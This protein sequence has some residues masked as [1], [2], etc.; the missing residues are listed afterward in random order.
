[1]TQ[2]DLNQLLEHAAGAGNAAPTGVALP[3]WMPPAAVLVAAGA[4][5]VGIIVWLFGGKLIKPGFVLIGGVLGSAIGAVYVPMV[6]PTM[7]GIP[8]AY[9]G[10]L[11]GL[12]FGMIIALLVYRFAMACLTAGV[13]GAAAVLAGVISLSYFP[14]AIPPQDA[15]TSTEGKTV[16]NAG[17]TATD[18]RQQVEDQVRDWSGRLR[19]A[20]QKYKDAQL[21]AGAAGTKG[22]P[23]EGQGNAGFVRTPEEEAADAERLDAAKRTAQAISDHLAERWQSLPERSR[24]VIAGAWMAGAMA[25]FL[26]GLIV[27]NKGAA[28][29]SALTGAAMMLAGG[30]SALDHYAALGPFASQIGPMGWLGAWLAISAVGLYYQSRKKKKATLASELPKPA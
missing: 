30:I 25:G 22:T 13:V 14:G 28:A 20:A 26:L 23:A 2:Q 17:G 19:D 29:V 1:M 5:V 11:C 24:L 4:L 7:A 10:M 3:P 8:S 18:L 21:L 27:P 6:T 16:I 12:V 15:I 9:P